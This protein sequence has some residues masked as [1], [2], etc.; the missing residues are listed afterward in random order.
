MSRTDRRPSLIL[1]TIAA[2][3][4]LIMLLGLGAWQLARLEW[5]TALIE[6]AKERLAQPPLPWP[7]EIEDAAAL[8]YRRIETVFTPR[9]ER[10]M[11][12]PGG[13]PAGRAGL[14]VLAASDVEGASAPVLVDLGWIPLD[15]QQSSILLP[16]G[17]LQVTGTLRA[18]QEPNLLTPANDAAG[19]VWYWLDLPEMARILEVDALAPVVI[20]AERIRTA[21]GT[22]TLVDFPLQGPTVLTSPT[23]T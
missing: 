6:T 11:F 22:P 7:S 12:Q 14:R 10:L 15:M 1:A 9:T 2:G 23:T 13:S 16:E 18:P 17:P 3:L 19:G 5:K 21:D 4:A 8:D 20:R